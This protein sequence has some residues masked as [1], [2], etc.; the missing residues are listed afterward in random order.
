MNNT[1]MGRYENDARYEF[2]YEAAIAADQ[3]FIKFRGMPI[4]NAMKSE[5]AMLMFSCMNVRTYS[6][7]ETIYEAGTLSK[8]EISLILEGKVSASDCS[9]HQ[10][11]L[12]SA[13]DV[14]GLFSFLDEDRLHSATLKAEKDVKVLVI[15][16]PYFNVITL[17]DPALG[18]QL[19]QFMFRLLSKMALQL[20]HEYAVM[21]G[22]AL[23][24]K[25]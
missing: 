21:H 9:G 18:N 5:D 4:A 23:G 12:L 1:E 14:F 10:Y 20:E 15:D 22:F 13:G 3:D 17:E 25:F 6:A 2:G 8:S 16:R 24:R 7:G 19:L 11:S